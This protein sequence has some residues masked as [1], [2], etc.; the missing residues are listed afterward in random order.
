MEINIFDIIYFLLL[1]FFFF[2]GWKKGFFHSLVGP[3]CLAFWF[4]IGVMNYDL[5]DNIIKSVMITIIGSF[6]S[7]LLIHFL[8]FLG[9]RSVQT[10]HRD[11]V[12]IV[13]RLLGGI[14]N[15]GWNGLLAAF[16]A[17]ILSLMPT[18]FLGLGNAQKAI[19]KS[20]S[21]TKFY[22]HLICPF[23]GI[24]NLL[25]T[26]SVFKNH[27]I[28]EDYKDT[29]EYKQVFSHPKIQMLVQNLPLMK[30]FYSQDAF[31]LLGN[32]DVRSIL[33][34]DDLIFKIS[35]LGK[36]IY[37]ERAEPIHP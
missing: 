8:L 30:K 29:Y 19:E 24:R 4:I 17:I 11:Y 6:F 13:S 27:K 14:L 28:L 20:I 33:S 2:R 3:A 37:D 12:F 35:N 23:P 10:P 18:N 31:F 34:D 21:Y 25:I 1:G 16:I 5:N 22:K 36:R 15:M 32:A 7:A 9:H 26:I